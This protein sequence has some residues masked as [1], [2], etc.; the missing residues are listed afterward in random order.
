MTQSF[1]L[2]LRL[3]RWPLTVM[4][5][6]ACLLTCAAAQT[7]I[8]TGSIQGTVTDPSG[9]VVP[10]AKVTI[11]NLDTNQMRETTTSSSGNYSSGSLLP[12]NY[13]V[14]VEAAGFSPVDTHVTVQI[15]TTTAAN[16]RMSLHGNAEVVEVR[17]GTSQVNTEQATVQGVLNAEQIDTL[18]INGRNFLDLAQLEPGVQVQDG[19]N[20]D[21][22]K[23]GFSGI[24]VGG[25]QGR[26]TRI[27]VDG[28]DV[29]DEN[30]GTTLSNYSASAIQEFSIQQSTLDLA[31]ELTS[32]GAVNVATRTGTNS[33]H[34]EGFYLFRDKALAANFTGGQDSPYQRNHFGGRFGGPILK[35]KLF[36]FLNA[37]RVRQT[38]GVPVSFGAPFDNL[39]GA[40][41]EPFKERLLFGRVDWQVTQSARAF[42]RINYDELSVTTNGLPD[43]SI[44]QNRNKTPAQ[45]AGIDFSTGNWNHSIRYGYTK[46][47]NGIADGVGGSGVFN[48]L[49]G[50]QVRIGQLRAG[51]NPNAPQGTLQSNNQLK[52]DGS[53]SYGSH[54]FRYGFGY[55]RILAGGFANFYGSGPRL[56]SSTSSA[57]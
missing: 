14:K 34:G 44:F 1:L 48:P 55:N 50:A 6:L 5:V 54:L 49:P 52:Y 30:V 13:G 16:I 35:D 36:F 2:T 10:N 18:P 22:T 20:F 41:N 29:T 15:S 4:L 7:T 53:R 56:R 25:R 27:E 38:L 9:A 33:W 51:P 37:E 39:T 40:A 43:Y 42:Y 45:A 19:A 17:G 3:A 57:D 31:S 21:P 47:V 8:A 24:S 12:G 11:T 23:G 28:L 46:F 26:S 32:S